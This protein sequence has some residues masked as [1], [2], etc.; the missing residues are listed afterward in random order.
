MKKVF[1]KVTKEELDS[2]DL[3]KLKISCARQAMSELPK[4]IMNEQIPLYVQSNV[5]LLGNYTW[6]EKDWWSEI[7]RKYKITIEP[8]WIDF[9]TG[10]LYGV[11]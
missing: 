7:I 9:S 3:I 10:E 4:G 1:A 11:E 6:L 8:V 2:L 5:D